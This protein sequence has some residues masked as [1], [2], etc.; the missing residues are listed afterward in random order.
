MR[1]TVILS[2]LGLMLPALVGCLPQRAEP[3]PRRPV[4]PR[5]TDPL[6]EPPPS[7]VKRPA[8]PDT[9]LPPL[10]VAAYDKAR[11][12]KRPP[13]LAGKLD[14]PL[15]RKWLY[16]VIHHS[17]TPV[18]SEAAFHRFHRDVKGWDGIGYDFVIGNGNGA[19]DG[20]VEVTYRWEKQLVGA[21]AGSKLYNERG[22][23]ICLVGDLENGRMSAKQLEALVGLVNYLQERCNIPTANIVGHS[24]VRPRGTIC[25]GKNFPWF[26][27]LPRLEH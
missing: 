13:L 11:T 21:H 6:V 4:P 24:Q 9:V 16:I 18:G 22:I 10:L 26:E 19:R 2:A 15:K 17:A 7:I 8:D 23:G 5:R 3:L 20:L 14:A 12:L 27:L 25:P 1:T